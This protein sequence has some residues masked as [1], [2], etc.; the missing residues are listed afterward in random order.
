M[1]IWELIQ[2]TDAEIV[3][4]SEACVHDRRAEDFGKRKGGGRVSEEEGSLSVQ[5][6]I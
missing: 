1:K 6:Q 2:R 4:G 5:K 3:C